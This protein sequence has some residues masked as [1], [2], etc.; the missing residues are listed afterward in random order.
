M[1]KMG[2]VSIIMPVFN[3]GE[4]LA[5]SI[6]SVLSQTYKNIELIIINDNSSDESEYIL[7]NYTNDNRVS[8]YHNSNNQGVASC[9]NKGIQYA[10]GDYVYFMD[11][12]DFLDFRTIELLVNNIKNNI[13]IKGKVKNTNFSKAM[14]II[15]DGL[16]QPK[17]YN[18]NKY[19]LLKNR[20]CLNC[21]IELDFIKKNDVTFDETITAYTDL[22]F[23]V[24]LLRKLDQVLYLK[25]AIYFKRKRNDPINNPSISQYD[26]SNLIEDYLYSNESMREDIDKLTNEFLDKDLL[27]FYRKDIIA[28]F[29]EDKNIDK[30]YNRL[31]N[32]LKKIDSETLNEYDWF[33]K[34]EISRIKSGNKKNY[35][36]IN[37]QHRFFRDFKQ[38][39]KTKRKFYIFIYEYVFLKLKMKEDIVFL[40]S[41]LGKSYSD[42]PKHI[43]EYMINNNMNYKYVWSVREKKDIPGNPMQ[44]ER[45]SLRY[46][47]YLAKAKYWVSNARLPKYLTKRE[48]NVYLQT[49]HGTPLKTLVFDIKEIHSA[50]PKHKE[51]FYDESRKWDYLNSPNQYS[52]DIFRSAFKYDKE[53]LEFGYPRNDIL[54][55]KNNEKDINM[56]KDKIGIPKGKEVILYAPTWRDDEFFSRGNYKFSLHLDLKKMQEKF[57]DTHILMLRTHYHIANSIDVSE[58]EGFVYDRSK[59]DDIAE[60][61]LVSDMLITDYSSVFFDYAHLKRPI[62]FYTY[63]L[64]KYRDDLRGFYFDMEKEVPGPLLRTTDEVINSVENIDDINT[65]Y[66]HTYQKFYDKFCQ[67]DDGRASEKTVNTVFNKN[68]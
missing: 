52:S 49:W 45:F 5:E 24:P 43:Y 32:M 64:E 51:S 21:L 20:S 13:M 61:Y 41:F 17:L 8:I 11:S 39:F 9:R 19:N 67:W 35:K 25:E 66:S 56:L 54:Y 65:K 36:R 60:L 40:E 30:Y 29:K 55:T 28:Y 37:K 12:D 22:T 27:N 1:L 62:L 63:D 46:F 58:F 3:T 14:A 18:E 33:F 47:Y 68:S 31:Q 7:N 26:T 15:F 6:E 44:V 16:I 34:R 59:Y 42:N 57:G 38:A 2:K 10:S 4:Y 50:D 53:M 23:M 48:G